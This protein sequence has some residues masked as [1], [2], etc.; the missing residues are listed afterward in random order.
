MGTGFAFGE[1]TILGYL[2][3]FP[4]DLVAGWGSG[5]GC[6]GLIAGTLNVIVKVNEIKLKYLY[7]AVSP[8]TIV[9]VINFYI[10]TLRYQKDL[11][12]VVSPL[13][14]EEE[15]GT[16]KQADSNQEDTPSILSNR[17]LTFANAKEAFKAN[18]KLIINLA[19]VHFMEVTTLN[20]LSERVTHRGYIKN[21][22]FKKCVSTID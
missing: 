15:E 21:E 1:T 18:Y 2:R 14:K 5:I 22:F 4:N 3:M 8:V 17:V 9:Y 11:V 7:L 13:I 6:A 12:I 10:I 20:G 16:N 19:L